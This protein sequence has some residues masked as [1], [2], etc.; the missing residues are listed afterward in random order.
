MGERAVRILGLGVLGLLAAGCG[1]G[2]ATHPP[3]WTTTFGPAAT[4]AS[5]APPVR[6]F[7][8]KAM[9][10]GVSKV[11][12]DDFALRGFG[13]VICPDRQAV[14]DGNQF[15]CTVDVAGERRHVPIT[16]TGAEGRYRVDAPR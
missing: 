2:P 9:S 14:T 15:Q 7:D 3:G 5:S 6:F 8:A 10:A 16:V 4:G 12:T 1:S 11:L 13:D